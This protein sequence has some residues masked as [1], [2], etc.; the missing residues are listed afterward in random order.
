M[1]PAEVNSSIYIDFNKENIKGNPKFEVGDH[2]K[3]SKFKH[4]SKRISFKLILKIKDI[5][6]WIYVIEDLNDK[7]IFGMFCKK[8]LQKSNQIEFTVQKVI[9]RKGDKLYF[10]WK[11]NNN[12]FSSWI[13]KKDIIIWNELFSRTTYP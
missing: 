5:F 10:K 7:E 9:N 11:G 13:D 12:S 4:F 8:E 6:S 1:K 2:V 3:I